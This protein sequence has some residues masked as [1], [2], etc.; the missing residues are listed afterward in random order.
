MELIK[1]PVLNASLKAYIL[2]SFI[3]I[4]MLCL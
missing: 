2:F 4:N 1:E 3:E